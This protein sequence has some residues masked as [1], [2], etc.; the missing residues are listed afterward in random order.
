MNTNEEK[1]RA[2]LWAAWFELN[3]IRARDGA[4][5]HIDWHQGRPLQ[6]DGVDRQYFSDLV[7]AMSDTLGDDSQPWPAEYMKP[8]LLAASNSKGAKS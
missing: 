2:L 3:A 7:D 5:Q 4:P 6:T 8:H 1:L